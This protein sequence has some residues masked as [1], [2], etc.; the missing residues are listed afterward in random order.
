M[1]RRVGPAH[2]AR[3]ELVLGV[4]I[5]RCVPA[6]RVDGLGRPPRLNRQVHRG[7]Q[8]RLVVHH[9][10]VVDFVHWGVL[11]PPSRGGYPP[12]RR[13]LPFR[14]VSEGGRVCGRPSWGPW[15]LISA[16]GTPKRGGEGISCILGRCR[17]ACPRSFARNRLSPVWGLRLPRKGGLGESARCRWPDPRALKEKFYFELE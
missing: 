10:V 2:E 4:R 1:P 11:G 15:R 8:K 13:K 5:Q 16:P 3:R 12:P 17:Q 6:A 7:A 9:V 14:L